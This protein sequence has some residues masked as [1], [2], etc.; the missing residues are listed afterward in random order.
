MIK[1]FVIILKE[2]EENEVKRGKNY[3][4]IIVNLEKNIGDMI[5]KTNIYDFGKIFQSPLNNMYDEVKN[6]SSGLFNDFISLI[7]ESYSNY[8]SIVNDMKEDRFEI[9][10]E[11]REITKKKY[12]EYIYSSLN[13]LD[14]F[15]NNT[16]NYLNDL[17]E[18]IKDILN[19][20]IDVLYDIID[21]IEEAKNIFKNFCSL[22]FNSITKGFKTFKNDLNNYFDEMI[23]ELIYITEFISYGLENND[24]LRNSL[25]SETR[26]I[27][28]DK[29][30]NFKIIINTIIN[31]LIEGIFN[32][33][34]NEMLSSN[35]E[36][37][38]YYT[39]KK[40]SELFKE[41]DKNSSDLIT[42]IKLKIKYIEKY[43]LY[44]SNIDQ[45]NTINYNLEKKF[46]ENSNEKI[47]KQIM[48]IKPDF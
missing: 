27:T 41:F 12:I 32:D 46:D 33:Y 17:E 20:Q 4:E 23:G 7:D 45:I 1:D 21:N 44:S 8:T 31:H 30:K 48:N 34:N 6:F 47:I 18:L 25:D 11:I 39:E 36:S 22:L 40:A 3:S 28:I 29:L 5:N 15:S 9:F 2:L 38:K 37:I 43:E 24:I 19:F 26:N 16:M 14:T 42:S 13:H 35:P 10:K